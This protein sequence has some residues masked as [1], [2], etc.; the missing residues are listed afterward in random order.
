MNQVSN[1]R[2]NPNR[3][4][5]QISRK[6]INRT[7]NTGVN[8]VRDHLREVLGRSPDLMKF[9]QRLTVPKGGTRMKSKFF[10]CK[11]GV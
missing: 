1:G 6:T 11:S 4:S 9:T 3:G 7:G 2:R 5:L 10:F 8:G